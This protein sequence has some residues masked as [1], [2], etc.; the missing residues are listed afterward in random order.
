MTAEEV[1]DKRGLRP[2]EN[3]PTVCEACFGNMREE[4]MKPR[5]MDLCRD[6]K[7][8]NIMHWM[9]AP[10]MEKRIDGPVKQVE[11]EKD[12][13]IASLQQLIVTKDGL[14]EEKDIQLD[15]KNKQIEGNASN[16]DVEELK[17]M[18]A[19]KDQRLAEKENLVKQKNA[20][21]SKRVADKVR[22]MSESKDALKKAEIKQDTAV[23]K[24]AS[25]LKQKEDELGNYKTEYSQKL[26]ELQAL[27][28]ENEAK[29]LAAT[30]EQKKLLTQ[31]NQLTFES[32]KFQQTISNQGTLI[33][34][35]EDERQSAV[36]EKDELLVRIDG[37]TS[38]NT[39][40]SQTLKTQHNL[41]TQK[42]TERAAAIAER[43][44]LL[45]RVNQLQLDSTQHSKTASNKDSLLAQR[46]HELTASEKARQ[47]VQNMLRFEQTT[48][49]GKVKAADDRAQVAENKLA[50]VREI[51][52][53]R[54]TALAGA[55]IAMVKVIKER[56]S[57]QKDLITEQ[58]AVSEKIRAAVQQADLAHKTE[59][60]R[61][62]KTLADKE[63]SLAEK[64]AELAQAVE[65]EDTANQ[66]YQNELDNSVRA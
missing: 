61:V 33:A 49:A 55:Q 4:L 9:C 54:N 20:E 59:L 5:N 37:L 51:L 10:C 17:K 2:C 30:E 28:Q 19:L 47:T 34:Q 56:D 12:R 62:R 27:F 42:E 39:Q 6:C 63:A 11:T 18:I 36:A 21:L 15:E 23:Q 38:E 57:A 65:E 26:G 29:R 1:A 66:N 64:D 40:H 43:D 3:T 52:E 53:K 35:K 32:S 22:A 58:Q 46:E 14:L 44:G 48:T 45:A 16:T 31:I 25:Q 8:S 50:E 7:T 13:V 60:D 24:I 41:L